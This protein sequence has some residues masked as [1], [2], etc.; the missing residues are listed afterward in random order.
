MLPFYVLSWLFRN[1]QRKLKVNFSTLCVSFWVRLIT[2]YP[3]VVLLLLIWWLRKIEQN[4]IEY[5]LL[6]TDGNVHFDDFVTLHAKLLQ[7]VCSE[8]YGGCIRDV[9]Q[10]FTLKVA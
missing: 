8:I 1:P 10:S 3:T 4:I 2:T 9:F 7:A 6:C 5:Q